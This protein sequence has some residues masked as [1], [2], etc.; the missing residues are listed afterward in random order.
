MKK[1]IIGLFLLCLVLST[2]GAICSKSG[3]MPATVTLQ[4]WSA[5]L[6]EEEVSPFIESFQAMYPYVVIEFKKLDYDEYENEVINGWAKGQGPDIFSVQNTGVKKFS[7]YISPLPSSITVT[8]VEQK[9]TMGKKQTIVQKV[10]QKSISSS[11]LNTQFVDTVYKDAVFA[12]QGEDEDEATNKIYALPLSTDTL[13]LYWN[14]DLLNQAG[15]AVPASNWQAVADH[16]KELTKVDKQGNILQ[17]GVAMGTADNIP[18]YF[19]IM[20]VLMMQFGAE[21]A[22][23]NSIK[24][25]SEVEINGSKRLPAQEALDF[26]VKFAQD[27]WETYTWNE[28]KTNALDEFAAGN[29]AYYIGYHRDLQ[30]IKQ[31][32]PTLNFDVAPLPQ[33]NASNQ[34]NYPSYWLESV[35]LNSANSDLAWAFVQYLTNETNAKKYLDTNKKP[36]AR[37]NLI[38]TQLEDYELATFSEQALTAQS[39]YHGKNPEEA[40]SI[41]A[42]MITNALNEAFP[43]E[44]IVDDAAQKMK[45][46]L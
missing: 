6:T 23:D 41:F 12:I 19:D 24:F 18:H 40:A 36:A 25:N 4:Y 39:W 21:M 37:R 30:E 13:A 26:Y 17:S 38:S 32:A 31:L 3:T 9:S 27:K 33:I 14:K 8:T 11:E 10:A 7:E 35:S 5:D 28:T 20:S 44:D 45:L 34:V 43:L 2:S 15:I 42:Q 22:T 1:Y 46:T 29:L 16:T